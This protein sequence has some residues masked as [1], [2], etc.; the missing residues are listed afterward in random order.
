MVAAGGVRRLPV[1]QEAP[2]G[3]R[4]G[5]GLTQFLVCPLGVVNVAVVAHIENMRKRASYLSDESKSRWDRLA[6]G[7]DWP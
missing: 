4:Y 1:E 6:V 7:P 3:T 2:E 5:Q